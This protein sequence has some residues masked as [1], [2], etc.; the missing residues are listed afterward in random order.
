MKINKTLLED[1]AYG[2]YDRPGPTGRVADEDL[3]DSDFELPSEVPVLPTP[4]MANQISVDRP[5]I[6]DEDFVPGSMDE[7]SRSASAI[8]QLVPNE[9]I[10]FFYRQLHK[11]LDDATDNA[12]QEKIDALETDDIAPVN[13]QKDNKEIQGE[14]M[15]E[16][17][18]RNAIRSAIKQTLVESSWDDDTD[19]YGNTYDDQSGYSIIEPEPSQEAPSQNNSGEIS[20]EDLAS[21]F[22]YSGPSGVRQE[23][24][25]LTN[26]M[27][28][29]ATKVKK[30]DLDALLDY[31]VGEYTDVFEAS[32]I[33]D[34]EDIEDLR[35][36][37]MIVKKSDSF[38]Y[39][40]VSSFVLPAY[41]EIIRDATK[42]VKQEI[43]DMGIPKE[44][45]QTVFNQ[46]TGAATIKP[47]AIK[48]K[49]DKLVDE[50]SLTQEEA[51]AMVNKVET[52]RNVLTTMA[53]DYSDDLVQ[54]SLDK[55]QGVSKK[56]RLNA[57]EQ[58]LKQTDA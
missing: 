43:Q 51:S 38:R 57:L 19:A 18:L 26:R 9:S 47:A 30:N 58:A 50:K 55:W 2:I 4:Q 56:A 54:R 6:E 20:L 23:I 53:S 44:L 21:E 39:F 17:I 27:N 35:K 46:V 29:F 16:S 7:L 36:A 10:E 25:K 32:D 22:G 37:P 24:E 42:K 33:L 1:I 48:K 28:Y 11:L 13:V 15:K 3:E 52:T 45:H 5:P 14:E 41:R 49:L 31:A 8:S 12:Q 34:P 40:F